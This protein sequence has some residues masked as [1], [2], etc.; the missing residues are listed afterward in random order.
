MSLVKVN[1]SGI[2]EL[3]FPDGVSSAT[4]SDGVTTINLTGGGS[5]IVSTAGLTADGG[6][7]T[8]STGVKGYIQIPFAGTIIGWSLIANVSGTLAMDIWKVS[9]SAPPTAPTIPTSA[10]IISASAGPSLSSAQS[11]SVGSSGVSTW[12][13]A[14][15]QWDVLGFQLNSISTITRFTLEIQ[16]QR[17]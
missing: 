16:I 6:S 17:S 1:I 11:S 10:N 4:T 3:D 13:T 12:T 7:S 9:S 15:S 2:N 5:S 14:V 8:P